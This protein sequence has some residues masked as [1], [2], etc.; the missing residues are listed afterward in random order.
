MLVFVLDDEP[1]ALQASCEVIKRACPG[2]EILSFGRSRDALRAITEEKHI[3][4]V[5]FSD[6]EMPGMNGLAFA[7]ELKKAAPHTS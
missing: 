1:F 6:I 7:L 3:P 5:V 2:A 4:D